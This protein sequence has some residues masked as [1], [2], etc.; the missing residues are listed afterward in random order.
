[1]TM[2]VEELKLRPTLGT[3]DL[4]RIKA[5]LEKQASAAIDPVRGRDYMVSGGPDSLARDL[6]WRGRRREYPWTT[7]LISL[8]ED[9]V[10]LTQKKESSVSRNARNFVQWMLQNLDCKIY[11]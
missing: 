6:E 8:T 5:H 9:Q 2:F 3:F 11:D 4:E 1:M 7:T 10:L